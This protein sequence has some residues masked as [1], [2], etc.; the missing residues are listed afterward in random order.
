ML[1]LNIAWDLDE[2]LFIYVE[3]V[4]LKKEPYSRILIA[5]S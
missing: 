1:M 4:D 5:Y 3:A 2:L